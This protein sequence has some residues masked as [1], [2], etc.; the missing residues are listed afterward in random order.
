[1]TET[2]EARTR[3]RW[4]TM[5]EI[6][7]IAAL[8]ISGLS[9]WD[10]HQE[11]VAPPKPPTVVPAKEKPLVLTGT[12]SAARDRIDLR[13][14]S[15]DDVIQTQTIRFPATVRADAVDTTGN[16]RIEAG[17][18]ESG[19]RAALKGTKLHAGRHRLAVGIE[20]SYVAGD[21]TRTDR[22]VY[23][24]GYTL[25]ERM[26]RP[27]AVAIEGVSLV[28]RVN[29]DLQAAVDARFAGQLPKPE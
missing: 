22:A 3:R 11:R 28:Q 17:W 10:A 9:Y 29:G 20:T 25:H 16:A 7:G 2:T 1:M 12:L 15:S 26:L 8:I 6:I 24:L 23:D 4:I 14:A 27:D 18:F 21:A 19:L 5:G 13:P